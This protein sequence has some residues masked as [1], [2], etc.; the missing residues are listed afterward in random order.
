MV[1]DIVEKYGIFWQK[2]KALDNTLYIED[3]DTV[4][5]WYILVQNADNNT[6]FVG[7]HKSES[8][9]RKFSTHIRTTTLYNGYA[10]MNQ[11]VDHS[12]T[13][14]VQHSGTI[15][16]NV[17]HSGTINHNVNGSINHYGNFNH[18]LHY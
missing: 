3:P 7:Y 12:G 10:L 1:A 15:N 16:Q 8:R 13:V 2:N 5:N 9:T 11:H 17:Y 14:N 6:I 4:E 18:Y